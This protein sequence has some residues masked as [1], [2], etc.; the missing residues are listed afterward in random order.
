M[1]EWKIVEGKNIGKVRLFAI[2]TCGWCRRTKKLLN[3]LGISYSYLDV[4]TLTG[5]EKD[6]IEDEVRKW[7]P[8]VT[9]PT[10]IVDEAKC[11]VGFKEDEIKKLLDN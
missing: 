11:I 4:D 7:N 6:K 10:L 9:F 5:D 2:S 3:D 1:A 8:G